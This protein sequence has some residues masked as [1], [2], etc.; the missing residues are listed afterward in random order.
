MQE[1]NIVLIDFPQADGGS[2]LRPALILKHLSEV[3]GFFGLWNIH[4]DSSVHKRF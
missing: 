4:T 1:S 3:S 2:K